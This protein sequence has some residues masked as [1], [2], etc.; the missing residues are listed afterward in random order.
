M[1]RRTNVRGDGMTYQI[2]RF[3]A[4][5]RAREVRET[6]LTLE[7][8]QAHCQNPETSSRTTTSNTTSGVWFDGYE[9]EG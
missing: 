2:I 3:Y 5:D 9:H 8:A 6:G 1:A 4:D 7:D